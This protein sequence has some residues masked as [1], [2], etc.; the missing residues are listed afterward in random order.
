VSVEGLKTPREPA[1]A[2]PLL[3]VPQRVLLFCI[4]SGSD[5]FKAGVNDAVVTSVV[6]KNL[7][8]R[9]AGGALTLTDSG[10]A[11]LRALLPDRVAAVS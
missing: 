8:D 1:A 6:V 11:V 4:A 2:E 10:R 7:V 9:D 3:G 5:R